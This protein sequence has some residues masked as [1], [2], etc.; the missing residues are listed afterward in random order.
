MQDFLISCSTFILFLIILLS[1]AW[2]LFKIRKKSTN[3]IGLML[4]VCGSLFGL[5]FCLYLGV[6]FTIVVAT[7]IALIVYYRHLPKNSKEGNPV[8]LI[9]PEPNQKLKPTSVNPEAILNSVPSQSMQNYE[10]KSIEKG[11]STNTAIPQLKDFWNAKDLYTRRVR[12][13]LKRSKSE[14][15][16]IGRR[17]FGST[18][19]VDSYGET[20]KASLQSCTCPDFSYKQTPCK[21]ILKLALKIGALDPHDQLFGIP[22]ELDL[23]YQSLSKSSQ[24]MFLMLCYQHQYA[25]SERFITKRSVELDGLLKNGFIIESIDPEFLLKN[26]YTVSELRAILREYQNETGKKVCTSNDSKQTIINNIISEG[27][28]CISLFT[29]HNI[30]LEFDPEVAPHIVSF[31]DKYGN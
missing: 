3:V 30:I 28:K 25:P 26:A 27:D 31:Y 23:R 24:K 2:L 13:R 21:H 5:C 16:V 15:I 22:D 17:L 8:N 18:Y 9:D 1:L 12:E 29:S 14:D 11:S 7:V 10:E 19:Q 20:Y 4:K 6:I